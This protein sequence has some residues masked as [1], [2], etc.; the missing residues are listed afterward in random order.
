ML[1]PR[2]YVDLAAK[3]EKDADAA[4]DPVLRQVFRNTAAQWRSVAR[5]AARWDTRSA[6]P[7]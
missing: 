4:M 2:T 5:L 3:A 6:S 7:A 1:D